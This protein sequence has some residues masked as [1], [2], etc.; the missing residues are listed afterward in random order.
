MESSTSHKKTSKEN[1]RK[2]GFQDLVDW[3]AV[4]HALVDELAETIKERGMHHVL[5]G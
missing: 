5:S 2:D 1:L 4:Q 3:D